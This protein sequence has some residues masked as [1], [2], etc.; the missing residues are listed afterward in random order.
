MNTISAIHRFLK[1]NGYLI[2]A[3]QIQNILAR[4]PLRNSIRAISDT[5]DDM[6]IKHSVIQ[7]DR[8]G[9]NT[10]HYPFLAY[11]DYSEEYV[12]VSGQEDV[13]KI[14]SKGWRGFALN[15]H[16]DGAFVSHE[17][18][19]KYL[20]HQ[21]LFF[22]EENLYNLFIGSFFVLSLAI[23]AINCKEQNEYL[24][25]YCLNFIGLIISLLIIIRLNTRSN[26]DSCLSHDNKCAGL[27]SDEK[28]GSIMGECALAYFSSFNFVPVIYGAPVSVILQMLSPL[29]LPV[30]LY[31]L[32]WQIIRKS[33]CK[34]CLTVDTV[35]IAILV[36]IILD[37][38]RQPLEAIRQNIAALCVFALCFMMPFTAIKLLNRIKTMTSD[39]DRTQNRLKIFLSNRQIFDFLLHH[40]P[41]TGSDIFQSVLNN[42]YSSI[43]NKEPEYEITYIARLNCPYCAKHYETLISI[44]DV[45]INTV[46]AVSQNDPLQNTA[47]RL[48][49]CALKNKE[50]GHPKDVYGDWCNNKSEPK[51]DISI[52]AES[53][54]S[55]H[56]H[57]LQKLRI[58]HFPT[59]LINGYLLPRE[60]YPEDLKYML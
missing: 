51:A 3:Y 26:K 58:T 60:Y 29:T 7:F 14:I 57:F 34:Y 12:I 40:A 17:G 39:S 55:K 45:R 30:V 54:L 22:V 8:N 20:W 6:G 47:L 11:F 19:C 2:S 27:L 53:E 37:W 21:L 46:L 42:Q 15:V 56:S 25:F 28:S 16:P 32:I 50:E 35:L 13:Q 41:C 31:S 9:L 10:C 1:M 38:Q 4:H 18:K 49:S 36:L 33:F 43:R 5:L 48:F 44:P 52:D 59:I 24:I 23:L